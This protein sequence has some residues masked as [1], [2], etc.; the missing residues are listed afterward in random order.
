VVGRIYLTIYA[1]Y[2]NA[3]ID[4]KKIYFIENAVYIAPKL[5]ETR[6]A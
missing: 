1:G 3:K 6:Y 4:F 5:A 2:L